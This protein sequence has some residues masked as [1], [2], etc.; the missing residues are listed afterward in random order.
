MVDA[1]RACRLASTSSAL[2]QIFV[3][4]RAKKYKE[5]TSDSDEK[6]PNTP[7]LKRYKELELIAQLNREVLEGG[8]ELEVVMGPE[9]Y[10]KMMRKIQK[11]GGILPR[12]PWIR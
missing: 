6:N 8:Q 9:R 1:C 7:A 2:Y 12:L 11:K 3:T 4:G 5:I 10:A